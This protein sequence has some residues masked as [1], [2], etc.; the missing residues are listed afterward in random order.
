VTLRQIWRAILLF[1]AIWFA[2]VT[3]TNLGDAALA[4]GLLPP[5]WRFASGNY[6]LIAEVTSRY[7]TPGWMLPPLFAG[8][9]AWEALACAL[10]VRAWRAWAADAG[11][12]RDAARLA[13][14]VSLGLWAAFLITDE[15]FVAFQVAGTHLRLFI[16]HLV[17]L[18]ALSQE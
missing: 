10:F 7:A 18:I 15:V 4:A 8:V 9:I 14:G 3:A 5:W 17:C 11:L 13:Y 1:W 12:G 2:V 6:A 16:A